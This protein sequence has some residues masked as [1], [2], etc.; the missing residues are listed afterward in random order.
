MLVVDGPGS[1]FVA[2]CLPLAGETMLRKPGK[3][4]LYA[5]GLEQVMHCGGSTHLLI[6]GITTEVCV[7]TTMREVND[8]GFECQLVENCAASYFPDFHRASVEMMVAQG[9]IVG[10]AAT[11]QPLERSTALG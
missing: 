3:G 8:R 2:E 1:D 6:A 7:Q 11:R 4:A 9:G 5:T 10:G